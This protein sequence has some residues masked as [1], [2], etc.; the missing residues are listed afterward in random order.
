MSDDVKQRVLAVMYVAIGTQPREEA[1]LKE[2]GVDSLTALD[3]QMNL[4]DEFNLE[5]NDSVFEKFKTAGDIIA[6][7]VNATNV[8]E[9]RK[10][11]RQSADQ[12]EDKA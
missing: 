5:I 2:L 11:R 12:A 10:A 7:V 3:L 1:T 8:I 4:E 9:A 6:Y